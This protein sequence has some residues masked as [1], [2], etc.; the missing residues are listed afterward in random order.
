MRPTDIQ[1]IGS[2]LAIHWDDNQE[3]FIP[4]LTLRRY[5]PCASCAGEKDIFG[6]L[7][8]GPD[9]PLTPRA[10]ELVRFDPIG[11]YAVQPF[12]ADGHNTGLYTF[13]YLRRLG[14][15]AP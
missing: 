8:K 11:G 15:L 7:Y 3:S 2:D 6:N 1:I 10:S 4:L 12:W 9:K 14:A 13:E 5:C